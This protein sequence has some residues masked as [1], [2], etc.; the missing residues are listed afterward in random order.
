MAKSTYIRPHAFHAAG[1]AGRSGLMRR[2]R[3]L[4]TRRTDDN[5]LESEERYALAARGANDGLWDWD[6]V[7]D[8]IHFSERWKSML[9]FEESELRNEKASWF[10]RIHSDDRK[11][12]EDQIRIHLSGET[13]HFEAE[14][15]ML[16]ESGGYR[17]MLARGVA[18]RDNDGKASRLAGSQ[19]DV[20]E[21]KL[22]AE[23]LMRN[24]F[25]DVLTG[26]PNRMLFLDRVHNAAKRAKRHG[27]AFAVLFI[28]L[29]RFKTINDGLGHE[30]GNA[31]LLE[32]SRRLEAI[33]RPG[34]TVARG[35]SMV[36]RLGGDEFTV[37][38]DEIH[39][40]A[41]AVRVA[42]RIS[43][44][45]QKPVMVQGHEVVTT[46]SIG[47]AV[48]NSGFNRVEDMLR[49]ADTAMH[50]AKKLGMAR[51]E[52]CD[53]SMQQ[54]AVA[55]L[56]VEREL[57]AAL[58]RNEL[59]VMYQPIISLRTGEIAAVEA[60]VR[61]EHPERGLLA[62]DEFIGVAEDAGLAYEL[63][64]QVLQV[65]CEQLASWQRRLPQSAALALC[66]NVSGKALA[67]PEFP[68]RL[69]EIIESTGVDPARIKLELTETA[70]VKN[71][72]GATRAMNELQAKH[73][74]F[75]ID[76]FGTGYSSFSYLQRFPI[77]T[78][79]ID[80]SFVGGMH[81]ENDSKRIVEMMV[82]LAGVLGMRAVAEG[83]ETSEQ[84]ET[85]R[86][87][88]CEYAQGFFFSYP[89]TAEDMELLIV[90]PPR[91]LN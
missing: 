11:Q 53:W 75:S 4:T 13:P 18:V 66:V 15:R 25:H 30:A 89:L 31:L 63:G 6:L 7:T 9:G 67:Y 59:R 28:D 47:I 41:D 64:M 71:L 56:K 80:K 51:Y 50:R 19:T 14:Y 87:L 46:A 32:T 42:E 70:I 36:A 60:L 22:V 62:P 86:G 91:W 72:D 8:E 35:G 85:L 26:L 17:W 34:D 33:I 1:R 45:I 81:L 10:D 20:T 61:W 27:S 52:I 37:L 44:E 5:G 77:D 84:L 55:Q 83:V 73:V 65:S 43:E 40:V 23:E 79:K 74:R 54:Q 82:P 16:D 24:A 3:R 21:R 69:M 49:D 48:S 88:R 90:T 29:D 68:A 38:V 76:D 58:D 12:L 39:D 57:R 78:L 2:E